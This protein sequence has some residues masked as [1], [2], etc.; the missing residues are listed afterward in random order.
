VTA[1][2]QRVGRHAAR[3]AGFSL[4]EVL[5]SVVILAFIGMLMYESIRNAGEA[6]E[7]IEISL[8]RVQAVRVAL[9][10]MVRDL[11]MAFLSKH[12]D[13]QMG[14]KPRTLFKGARTKV[15]FTSLAHT[16]LVKHSKESDQCEISY[17]LKG[18][19]QVR[20][21]A[22]WRRESRRIDAEPLKGGPSLVLLDDVVRLELSY[23][24]GKDCTDDCWKDRWDTT[25]LD[26]MPERLPQRVRIRLTVKDEYGRDEKWETQAILPI[27]DPFNF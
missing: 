3:R 24:D 2:A 12:K 17:W 25:Q 23:W 5:V 8:D 15:A 16:R 26:G 19:P 7:E 10:K 20:G 13:P 14:D 21:E 6:K 22:I 4:V 18:G 9:T 27:Q 1:A 11:S